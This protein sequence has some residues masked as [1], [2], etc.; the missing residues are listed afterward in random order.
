[1]AFA[2]FFLV[3]WHYFLRSERGLAILP[4]ESVAG[5]AI[6]YFIS[7]FVITM[8]F[9]RQSVKKFLIKR[10]FRLYPVI[11][12]ILC[13][14]LFVVIFI[15]GRH[16]IRNLD[17]N[18]KN[19]LVNL[20]FIPHLFPSNIL[21]PYDYLYISTTWTICCDFTFYFLLILAYKFKTPKQR[22]NF[23]VILS[24]I[25][26][27]I[28][29]ILREKFNIYGTM[30]YT[31]CCLLPFYFGM[32]SYYYSKNYMTKRHFL[33]IAILIFTP[34]IFQTLYVRYVIGGLLMW[35][36]FT[37]HKEL[38]NNKIVRF[39]AHISY[40]MFLIHAIVPILIWPFSDVCLKGIN[41][42]MFFI[43]YP[44]MI[45]IC[46]FIYRFIE[47]PC[48]EFGRRITSNMK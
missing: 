39:F 7:G 13:V 14:S 33:I 9:E 32:A 38:G 27:V 34:I 47:K 48:N 4:L 26:L 46:Y 11:V 23:I 6:F 36:L 2:S 17:I 12:F 18:L 42:F 24:L 25:L 19:I 45:P 41:K 35:Y 1:M 40:P 21:A 43:L 37:Y 3:F 8:S 30:F 31:L 5:T 44:A 15:N 22:I 29:N 28:V 20:T 10:F 16:E